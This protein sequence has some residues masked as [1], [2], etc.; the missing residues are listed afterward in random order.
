MR[1]LLRALGLSAA[2]A[3]AAT[4]SAAAPGDQSKV[5]IEGYRALGEAFKAVNDGLRRGTASPQQMQLL[6]TRISASARAQY[7]WFPAGS[8]PAPGIKTA[9]RPEIWTRARAFR[10]AQDAF[11]RQASAFAQVTMAGDPAAMRA[12][13]R[14]LGASCKGCHDSFRIE[15]D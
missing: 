13:A 4:P 12:A 14:Q 5:R 15:S 11:T 9:A 10:A 7:A 1:Q 8:G 6:A 3:L 2:C